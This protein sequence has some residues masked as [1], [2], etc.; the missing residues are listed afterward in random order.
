MM[1][2][3]GILVIAGPKHLLPIVK[4]LEDTEN[5]SEMVTFEVPDDYGEFPDTSG[6]TEDNWREQ[7]LTMEDSNL[8]PYMTKC[9]DAALDWTSK[10]HR[11]ID[12]L[13]YRNIETF[14]HWPKFGGKVYAVMGVVK[15]WN[16]FAGQWN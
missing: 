3:Y 1:S 4:Q 2:V 16:P 7:I 12:G 11:T 14:I 8:Y 13:G 6:Y 9:M 15:G 5:I 10:R